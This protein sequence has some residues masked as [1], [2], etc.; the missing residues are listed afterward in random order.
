MERVTEAHIRRQRVIQTTLLFVILATLPCYCVGFVLLG[1]APG[2]PR[3]ANTTPSAGLTSTAS[4]SQPTSSFLPTI[5]PYPTFPINT[6]SPLLP[7]PTQINL[8]PAYTLTWTSL[9]PTRLPPTI[10]P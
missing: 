2:R 1:V 5:T 4:T 3:S 6:L 7:T 10:T 8:F 9:P